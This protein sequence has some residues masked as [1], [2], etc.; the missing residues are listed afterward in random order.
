M[1]TLSAL[2][3]I[4]KISTTLDGGCRITLDISESDLALTKELL[5]IKF[6][7]GG[8]VVVAFQRLEAK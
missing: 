4:N 1:K 3:I 7:D 8:Q 6:K 2:A 5:E